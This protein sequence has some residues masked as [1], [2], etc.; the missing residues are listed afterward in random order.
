MTVDVQNALTNVIALKPE[1]FTTSY[2]VLAQQ[3]Q[4]T[5]LRPSANDN[6]APIAFEGAQTSQH[7]LEFLYNVA[8]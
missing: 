8:R 7:V 1:G 5:D 6:Y 4:P 3:F 2:W